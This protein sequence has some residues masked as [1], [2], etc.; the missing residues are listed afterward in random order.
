MRSYVVVEGQGEVTAVPNLLTRLWLDL[1]LPQMYWARPIRAKDL[2]TQAG[3]ERTCEH[4]RGKKDAAALLVLRDDDD[5]CPKRTGPEL[6]GW[7]QNLGLP[8]PTA[9]VL[10][11][12]EYESIFLASL[13]TIAG[14]P[15]TDPSG[16]E[17]SGVAATASYDDDPESPRDPKGWLSRHY[18]EG[19]KYKPTLDQLPMT[20]LVD[21]DVVRRRGLRWFVTLQNGL[22]FL[23][24]QTGQPSAV[25]PPPTSA[26]DGDA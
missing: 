8:F 19:R 22:R 23:A 5:G 21:F 16:I 13:E 3:F 14:K 2:Y 1:G 26:A 24:A 18:P 17:R 10:S 15:I 4:V 11:F 9:V 12:R 25:Y 6:A 20:R 7:A